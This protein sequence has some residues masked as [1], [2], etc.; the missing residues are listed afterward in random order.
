MSG[1]EAQRVGL[2]RAF[3]HAGRVVV[4]DDATSSLDTATELQ[5]TAAL[6][7]RLADRAR[8]VV[9]HRAATAAQADLVAWVEGGRVR[10][11]APHAELWADPGYR[12]VFAADRAR[13]EA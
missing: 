11:V 12:A 2:A 5:V 8:L 3:A 1:G 7:R 10:A 4:L 9:A 13:Q 6:T